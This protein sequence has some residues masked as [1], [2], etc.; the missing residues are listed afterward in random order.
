MQQEAEER[1]KSFN[2]YFTHNPSTSVAKKEVSPSH[3][4]PQDS[5]FMMKIDTFKRKGDIN[6]ER[7]AQRVRTLSNP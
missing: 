1:Y 7:A 3:I 4:T 2:P 5:D 6:L